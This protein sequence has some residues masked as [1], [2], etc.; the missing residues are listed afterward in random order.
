MKDEMNA[1]DKFLYKLIICLVL[2]VSMILLDKVKVVNLNNIRTEMKQNV[3]MLKVLR[4]VN[5]DKG[6]F[7]PLDISDE[8]VQS[9][10]QKYMNYEEINGGKRIIISDMQGVEAYKDGII[11]KKFQN[12]DGTYQVTV[13][14]MDDVEYIYDNLDTVDLNIYK[15]VKS[16]DIIGKPRTVSNKT[17]FD[18]Y[19][20]KYL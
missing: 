6:V 12:K 10:S 20:D 9:V 17:Y 5:G 8:V 4:F 14:G 3:N 16:G 13:K 2:L 18:F 19:E 11:I 15:I 7:L 1:I